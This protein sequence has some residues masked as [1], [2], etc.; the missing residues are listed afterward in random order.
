M[1]TDVLAVELRSKAL[2]GTPGERSAALDRLLEA[3]TPVGEDFVSDYRPT[4]Y[5]LRFDVFG[6]PAPQGSKTKG[7]WGNIIDDNKEALIPWREAVKHAALAAIFAASREHGAPFIALKGPL[8]TD[9][10]LFFRRPQNHYRTGRNAHLLR[11]DA[12]R[13]HY[14]KPDGDKLL[15]AC[16]D[17]M[18]DAGVWIDDCHAATGSFSKLWADHRLPGACI[19]VSAA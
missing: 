19:T 4:P 10:T 11:D 5:L 1:L 9:V 15:R 6:T 3:T 7:R 12:P 2:I 16:F 8:H 18:T 17:A 14:K 13:L